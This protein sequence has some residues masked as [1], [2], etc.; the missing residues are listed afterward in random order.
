M[1]AFGNSIF[2]K[3]YHQI[4]LILGEMSATEL[5]LSL[6]S[7]DVDYTRILQVEISDIYGDYVTE[8]MPVK[9]HLGIVKTLES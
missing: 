3:D 1:L 4:T 9:V 8:E 7:P 5:R 6:G 2:I